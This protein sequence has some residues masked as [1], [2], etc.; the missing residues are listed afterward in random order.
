MERSW[1][2][3]VRYPAPADHGVQVYQDARELA[4][5]VAAYLG[6]GFD[7]GEP[8]LVL[9]TP[10]H[11]QLFAAGL[12]ERGHDTVELEAE[13]L[14]D[15]DDAATIL[16]SIMVDGVLSRP[17][18]ESVV[19]GRL[20]A[21]GKRYPGRSVRAFGEL[22]DLLCAQD[23]PAAAAELEREWHTLAQVRRFSLLCGYELDVFDRTTQASILP[24]VCGAH[25]HVHVAGDPERLRKAVDAAL[26][27]TLGAHGTGHVYSLIAG[28]IQET[29]LP[30]SQLALMWVSREM[31]V[32]ASRILRSAR[33][34]Y[35]A[36]A[37]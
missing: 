17:R 30:A 16:D 21:L 26:E 3:F 31:P 15:R 8:A 7:E 22:V 18:F 4:E 35:L 11:W 14:L 28:Q 2:R 19:G 32:L 10:E 6:A 27:E 20:D 33:A 37:T 9:A 29:G 25:S 1:D 13:G 5:S 12:A 24:D 34:G 36:P 23:D